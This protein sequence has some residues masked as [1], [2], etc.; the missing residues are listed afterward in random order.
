MSMMWCFPCGYTMNPDGDTINLYYGAA[1][2]S[3]ALART[4]VRALLEW[5]D[6]NGCCE[7][8]QRADDV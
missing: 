5:L 4:S 8:R 3:I 6:T 1:D 2:C 7:R